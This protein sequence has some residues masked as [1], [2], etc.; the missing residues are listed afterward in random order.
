MLRL[1]SKPHVAANLF[2]QEAQL[3]AGTSTE[4]D[5]AAATVAATADA[6]TASTSTEADKVADTAAAT[7]AA[8]AGAPTAATVA[9]GDQPMDAE[10]VD[11]SKQIANC[12]CSDSHAAQHTVSLSAEG[13]RS[14]VESKDVILGAVQ[15]D[16]AEDVMP[17]NLADVPQSL[18]AKEAESTQLAP[19]LSQAEMQANDLKPEL[20]H[21]VGK[22]GVRE[23]QLGAT[24]VPST[25]L[26][27]PT[28]E[29]HLPS[30]VPAVP[31]A[32]RIAPVAPQAVPFGTGAGASVLAASPSTLA[33]GP[34]SQEA[35]PSSLAAGPSTLAAAPTEQSQS[36]TTP[37]FGGKAHMHGR[38]LAGATHKTTEQ[39][40][41]QGQAEP[42][43]AADLPI[44]KAA[45]HGRKA[46]DKGKEGKSK[47]GPQ[48]QGLVAKPQLTG[49]AALALAVMEAGGSYHLLLL[50][51]CRLFFLSKLCSAL[52]QLHSNFSFVSKAY[53]AYWQWHIC[54][55]VVGTV[56][57]TCTHA[58]THACTHARMHARTHRRT[59]A[60]THARTHARVY[61]YL[62]V[63][64]SAYHHMCI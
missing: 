20:K 54:V 63:M 29:G 16:A 64:H 61:V 27:E 33:A 12:V 30:A 55:V 31:S 7:V 34:S 18:V 52:H 47:G 56:H 42:L 9:G 58:R 11:G 4:A 3:S 25:L 26:N 5:T 62:H 2:A 17:G 22:A 15:S 37:T 60:C 35:G 57:D 46:S 50:L 14:A 59:H 49:R 1:L 45:T 10:T 36:A 23:G 28:A 41:S 48:G 24:D 6:P 21:D 44:E 38:Q 53:M 19:L 32:V 13:R 40:P 8:S 39:H 51:H 43:A